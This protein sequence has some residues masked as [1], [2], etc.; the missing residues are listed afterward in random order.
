MAKGMKSPPGACSAYDHAMWATIVTPCV[1]IVKTHC[2]KSIWVRSVM[3]TSIKVQNLSLVM[4]TSFHLHVWQGKKW[5]TF[6]FTWTSF[7]NAIVA[8]VSWNISWATCT[9]SCTNNITNGYSNH[10]WYD[11]TGIM[12]DAQ[13]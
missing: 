7:S 8:M 9:H 11:Y 5:K 10:W 4:T 1:V 6:F 3:T 13:L 12:K 2:T